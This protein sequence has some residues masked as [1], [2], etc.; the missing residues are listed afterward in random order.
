MTNFVG[1]D[2]NGSEAALGFVG[3]LT[4][5]LPVSPT[6]AVQLE[7]LFAQ[8]GDTFDAVVLEGGRDYQIDTRIN[9]LEIPV[10]VRFGI[11]LSELLDAGAYVGGYAGIPVSSSVEVDGDVPSDVISDVAEFDLDP[12]IDYG[13]LIGVDVGS[14]PFYVDARYSL[15]LADSTDD[16]PVFG[17]DLDRKNSAVSLTFGYRFGGATPRGRR[18]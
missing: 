15:G 13:A 1:D 2:A 18:Y 14:G 16:D 11:P 10:S 5:R 6:V 8:K 9:Y 3:G 4:S 12:A 17:P 7:A